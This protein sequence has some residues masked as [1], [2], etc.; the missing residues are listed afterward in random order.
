MAPAAGFQ[1]NVQMKR[2]ILGGWQSAVVMILAALSWAGN[3]AWGA[4]EQ[5]AS[6]GLV[7]FYRQVRPILQRN[8]TG[9]HQPAKAGGKLVLTSYATIKAGGEQG[10]GFE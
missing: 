8:C 10:L 1:E 2:G 9:C 6:A 5:P 7:S 3:T 4:D